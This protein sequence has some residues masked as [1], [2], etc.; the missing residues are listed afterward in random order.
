MY[1]QIPLACE[2]GRQPTRLR[3]VGL[4]DDRQLVIYWR[5]SQCRRHMYIVKPLFDCLRDCAAIEDRR[6]DA[7]L[8]KN[9]SLLPRMGAALPDQSPERRS[10]RG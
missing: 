9:T 7:R 6:P 3:E 4:T 1:R 2:C 10:P 8:T 5:C